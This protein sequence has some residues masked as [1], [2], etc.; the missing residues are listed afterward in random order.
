LSALV[1]AA[2]AEPETQPAPTSAPAAPEGLIERVEFI[3][4]PLLAAVRLLSGQTGLNI[5]CSAEA[6]KTK[7]SLFLRDVTPRAAV[8]ELCKAHNLSYR[9]DEGT[10]IIRIST[11]EE[12]QRNLSGYRDQKTQVF[13]LLYPNPVDIAVA[14][15]DLFGD[16]VKLS[17][18]QESSDDTLQDLQTRLNRFDL[19][20]SRSQGL[21]STSNNG[22]SGGGGYGGGGAYGGAGGGY[23]GAGG[24][25]GGASGIST[26]SGAGYG[27]G[28]RSNF[29]QQNGRTSNNV[30]SPDDQPR[31]TAD[32]AN[33]LA[34]ALEQNPA[35]TSADQQPLLD[36]YRRRQ[37]N[38]YVTV[39]RKTNNIVV[40][41]GDSET[42]TEIG[43]LIEKLDVP[44]P[45]VMLEVKVLAIDL[46]DSFNSAFD[47]Q[48]SNGAGIAGGFTSGDIIAPPADALT[49]AAAKLSSLTPGGTGVQTNNAVFQIVSNNFRA[50]LQALESKNRVTQLA[51]PLLLTANNEVSR[52]F[53]GEEYPIVQNITSQTVV[54]NNTSTTAP[55]T[56]INF[57]PVGTTL[58]LTP[59]I[60]A[61]RTVTLRVLQENS[62]VVSGGA[63]IPIVTGNGTI[64]SQPIDIV[65]T[66]T[67]SGT[68]VAK[69]NLTL[70]VGGL[71]SE[72][73]NDQRDEVPILGKL[74]IVGVLFRRQTT[75]RSRTEF[76]IL[77]RPYV[78]NTPAESEGLSQKLMKELSIHPM[79]DH[80]DGTMKSFV[81]NEVPH[82]NTGAQPMDRIFR[83]HS[84]YTGDY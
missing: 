66:R 8:E 45:L 9:V 69:D 33:R 35:A 50:R 29:S 53:V 58:L 75:G 14:I 38:I 64:Q 12:F 76:V 10:G 56:T 23:G 62:Q 60:N 82:P 44:T 7:V 40:R 34:R 57:Q 51:A 49:G 41:S 43:K 52:L 63:T 42:M 37:A 59:N 11:V 81:P 84:V 19:I 70:A 46:T 2:A 15:R 73:V 61:D 55:N 27:G 13:T 4:A 24:Y 80:F 67:F 79:A 17:L 71:I 72:Q 31:L 16:R 77:I 20:D 74:P 65:S 32:Q 83:F 5:V 26:Y 48:F 22:Y 36:V 30:E 6:G 39:M 25:G 3:D 1:M 78:L 47:F 21:G 18:Q 28:G 68:V 54:N